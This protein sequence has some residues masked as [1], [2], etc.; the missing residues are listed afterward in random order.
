VRRSSSSRKW[1]AG[2][3]SPRERDAPVT[4]RILDPDR[5]SAGPIEVLR[6]GDRSA[7]HLVCLPFAGGSA[8]SFEPM[9]RHLPSG[10][11]V[12][13]I[14]RRF[15]PDL[16]M[17]DD[18]AEAAAA[19]VK[20]A[21]GPT[22][23]LGHSMGAV[24]AYRAAQI[25]GE[26][27]P[28]SAVLV[29]SAP[30]SLHR[31]AETAAMLAGES[32]ERLAAE[33][34]RLGLVSGRHSDDVLMRLVL[35]AFRRDLATLATYRHSPVPPSTRPVVL[36]GADDPQEPAD[37]ARRYAEELRAREVYEIDGDHLFVVSRAGQVA[38]LLASFPE[39]SAGNSEPCPS[40]ID[41]AEVNR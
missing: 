24:V 36:I 40:F 1:E 10:W 5:V 20:D 39:L 18:L 34:R 14:V 25:L 30:P 33:V 2:R 12:G 29:L 28:T 9:A 31:T 27:W 4:T 22:V 16:P 26:R 19:T 21:T 38:A 8:R 23:L 15:E 13:V 35:P 37:G 41:R 3:P 17:V 6:Q 7:T 32:Q 11:W